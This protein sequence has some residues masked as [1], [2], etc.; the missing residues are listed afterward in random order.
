MAVD[1]L[2]KKEFPTCT[3][4]LVFGCIISNVFVLLGNQT[5]ADALNEIGRSSA[6]WS[7][8]GRSI[9]DSLKSDLDSKMTEVSGLLLV[10]LE[11]VTLVQTS[12]DGILSLAGKQTDS[13]INLSPELRPHDLALL[14]A[15]PEK[16]SA[17]TPLI[18][19]SI[20]QV[21]H[22]VMIEV[23]TGLHQL[24]EK[25]RPAFEQVG[26]WL[27]K[28]GDKIQSGLQDF[29]VTLDRAQKIFD[30]VMSSLHGRGPN[31]AEMLDAVWELFDVTEDGLVTVE[32]L[33]L[34][35]EMFS[36]SAL[37]GD[38]AYKM[39]K[40]YD[41]DGNGRIEKP[42]LGKL[43]EDPLIPGSMSVMLRIYARKHSEI[44]GRVS[45][46]RVG[47]EV[48]SGVVNYIKLVC[49]SNM[50]KVRWVADRL[51]N[52]SLPLQF[53]ADVM[54]Q[55][56]LVERDPNAPRFSTAETGP[57]LIG[58]MFD[59]HPQTTLD[60]LDMMSN[61]TWWSSEGL[62]I[63]DQPDCLEMVTGWVTKA[64]SFKSSL[65]SESSSLLEVSE[66][67]SADSLEER[68]RAAMPATARKLAVE[69]VS[70]YRLE[71]QRSRE[72]ERSS[73]FGSQ[74]SQA[75]LNH[76]L[77][78]IAPS[79]AGQSSALQAIN[80]G[81]P[82]RPETLEF[83]SWLAYNASST[84]QMY[85][86]MCFT[87]SG[88]SSNSV[89]SFATQIQSM[90]KKMQGFLEMMKSYST[91][92][93]IQRLEDQFQYFA[94]TAMNDVLNLV[95]QRI[96]SLVN[97]SIPAF[98][99]AVH[100]AAH[101]AGV[102]LGTMIG[103]ALGKPVGDSLSSPITQTLS[104]SL[105]NNKTAE[106]IGNKLSATLGDVI[107][108]LTA[109]KLGD[110]AGNLFE[111]LVDKAIDQ[112]GNAVDDLLKRLPSAH[113]ERLLLFEAEI[114]QVF[115]PK[116]SRSLQDVSLLQN[117]EV[118]SDGG[119]NEITEAVSGAWEGMV[120]TLRTFA[121]LL[122][123]A[124]SVLKQARLE[125]MK[126]S[127]NLDSIF[128]VFEDRGPKTFAS[129]AET[130]NKIWLAYFMCLLPLCGFMLYYGFWAKGYFGGP[131]PLSEEDEA[132][133][134][135]PKTFREQ[136]FLCFSCGFQGWRQFHDSSICLWSV[137]LIFEI[138]VLLTFVV[139]ILLCIIAGIKTFLI[140]GCSQVYILEDKEIC[141]EALGLVKSF[142]ST[143]HIGNAATALKTE[144]ISEACES[145]TLLTCQ[146]LS[147]KMSAATLT[148]IFF[149]F[150]AS[151]F[152]MQM[153]FDSA[154]LHEQAR[155]RRQVSKLKSSN[156]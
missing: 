94:D 72:K 73:L 137:I 21:L 19:T 55:L 47:D 101:D 128:E 71:A 4:F 143:F 126:L 10:G 96:D 2:R 13:A 34:V 57:L 148:T 92:A 16:A 45:S 36:L 70:L 6:G 146:V 93:G 97:Q 28:F 11:H 87:Y 80:A 113:Q 122:P 119:I 116:S 66:D 43:V 24:L 105:N 133:I 56:C 8:V 81:A 42:E 140:A 152:S 114:D 63:D 153:L 108:N 154:I 22:S 103:T 136:C 64:R 155:F 38:M 134:E 51:G 5:T 14:Q 88:E 39:I 18:M 84:A 29:S 37:R 67:A 26:D 83:A 76:L 139:S 68:L 25:L 112:G 7:K 110:A 107:T 17:L 82:A 104:N 151:L 118:S 129:L 91:P 31:K 65:L 95:E 58:E 131:T 111:G 20:H 135:P 117:F 127:S 115:N 60:A 40:K 35:S 53:T 27:V 147:Q 144:D 138:V 69:S 33:R 79:D 120:N 125:V 48:A 141:T 123:Q 100:N 150:L 106:L 78:G 49:A 145:N 1:E 85:Q 62:D 50:T 99:R 130:W 86:Q 149:S 9:A 74:T 59:L 156:E 3:V 32:D 23:Q 124:V 142:L 15:S 46:A 102:R 12:L 109:E 52:T 98:D 44:A 89:D 75:L 54:A 121:N 61:T 30:Q 77:G 90:V 41:K 132:T